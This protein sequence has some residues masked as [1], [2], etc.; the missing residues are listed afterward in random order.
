MKKGPFCI[1]AVI[2][3]NHRRSI[4]ILRK[5]KSTKHIVLCVILFVTNPVGSVPYHTKRIVL[6][7]R[8]S[9]PYRV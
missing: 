2:G 5:H 3:N 7:R 8:S 4:D 6:Y 1:I 9:V